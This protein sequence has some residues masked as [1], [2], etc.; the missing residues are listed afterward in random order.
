MIVDDSGTLTS[1]A[2]QLFQHQITNFLNLNLYYFCSWCEEPAHVQCSLCSGVPPSSPGTS[3]P[4]FSAS[5]FHLSTSKGNTLLPLL[6]L[7]LHII[8]FSIVSLHQHCYNNSKIQILLSFWFRYYCRFKIKL[9]VDGVRS[10][11]EDKKHNWFSLTEMFHKIV[12]VSFNGL[13]LDC[14]N[15]SFQNN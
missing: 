1:A 3:Q 12:N 6:R 2:V 14:W 13:R 9:L 15:R 7:L 8:I 5:V 11:S 10:S 4:R